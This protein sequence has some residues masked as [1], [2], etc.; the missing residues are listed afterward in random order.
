[1]TDAPNWPKITHVRKRAFENDSREEPDMTD[2]NT[3]LK[4][5]NEQ[6]K[7]LH[8]NRVRHMEFQAQGVEIMKAEVARL[9]AERDALREEAAA[10]HDAY[11]G[12][13]RGR[14]KLQAQVGELSAALEKIERATDCKWT[15]NIASE[16][17]LNNVT[18]DHK[19]AV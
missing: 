14:E 8:A 13:K 9:T 2:E 16:A 3:A 6:L 17:T 5:E 7:R 15:R 4:A 19:T 18:S 10:Y 12:E 11:E 1:M